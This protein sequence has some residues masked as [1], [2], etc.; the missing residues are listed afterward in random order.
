VKERIDNTTGGSGSRCRRAGGR[1]RT[2]GAR[3][4]K[5]AKKRAD[6]LRER[7]AGYEAA[8]LR[9]HCVDLAGEHARESAARTGEAIGEVRERYELIVGELL[10]ARYRGWMAGFTR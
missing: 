5:C 3:G 1:E 8:C 6:S 9:E 4:K 7:E 2:T 10:A